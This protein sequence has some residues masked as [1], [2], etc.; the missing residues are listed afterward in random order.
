MPRFVLIHPLVFLIAVLC[1]FVAAFLVGPMAA[2]EETEDVPSGWLDALDVANVLRGRVKSYYALRQGK[3]AP[4]IAC[5]ES[6]QNLP[7]PQAFLDAERERP[8][9]PIARFSGATVLANLSAIIN[10]AVLP[11]TNLVGGESLTIVKFVRSD[12]SVSEHMHDVFWV[13]RQD[14]WDRPAS[15]RCVA[16]APLVGVW[17]N[18]Y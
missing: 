6:R 16:E 14:Q 2:A 4:G 5:A 10:V 11:K 7:F 1:V 18:E 15:W 17:R 13:A 12:K 3:P 8:A 9:V